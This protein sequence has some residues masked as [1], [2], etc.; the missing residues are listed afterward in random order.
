MLFRKTT[1]Q[2]WSKEVSYI[3]IRKQGSTKTITTD[4][5]ACYG[6]PFNEFGV[7]DSQLCAGLSNN[8]CKNPHLP[9]RCWK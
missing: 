3:K 8:I 9:F 6:A 2:C 4:K 5:L 7:V 1:Q